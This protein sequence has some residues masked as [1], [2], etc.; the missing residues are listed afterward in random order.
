MSLVSSVSFL[1]IGHTRLYVASAEEMCVSRMC[2]IFLASWRCACL[3]VFR[4]FSMYFMSS[5]VCGS[6]FFIAVSSCSLA[7][8]AP[9]FRGMSSAFSVGNN[10]CSGDCV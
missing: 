3:A 4:A 8:C 10:F 9:C 2:D 1:G 6:S 5:S 7:C